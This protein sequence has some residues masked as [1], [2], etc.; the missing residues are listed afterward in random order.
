MYE[1]SSNERENVSPHREPRFWSRPLVLVIVS[2]VLSSGISGTVLC[3]GWKASTDTLNAVSTVKL[4]EHDEKIRQLEIENSD[5]IKGSDLA[6]RD[7]LLD[8]KL[9]L[10]QSEI[11][12]LKEQITGMRH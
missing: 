11:A 3:F 12:G 8:A 7:Q 6:M 10:L 4:Q 2:I 5:R 9:S 1:G